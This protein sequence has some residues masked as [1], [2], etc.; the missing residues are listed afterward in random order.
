MSNLYEVGDW[1]YVG[2]IDN[3]MSM[4]LILGHAVGIIDPKDDKDPFIS[5]VKPTLSLAGLAVNKNAVLPSTTRF[6]L[7][8]N[9]VITVA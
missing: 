3:N 9:E 6:M 7:D 2:F 4:P 5:S 8:N 1:V